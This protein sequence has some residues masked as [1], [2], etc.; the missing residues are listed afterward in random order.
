MYAPF[1]YRSSP[2]LMERSV[3]ATTAIRSPY[4]RVADVHTTVTLARPPESRG[5]RILYF[6]TDTD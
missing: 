6:V 4:F 3:R 2:Q 5:V 1:V